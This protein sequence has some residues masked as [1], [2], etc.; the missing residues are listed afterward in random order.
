MKKITLFSRLLL[1]LM[2]CGNLAYAGNK[3]PA[4]SQKP[5][6]SIDMIELLGEL[7]DDDPNALD[8]VL[9]DVD[10]QTAPA[11]TTTDAQKTG[12]KK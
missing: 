7:G 11:N 1:I 3:K 2:V 9:N 6:P 5:P 12:V 4:E 10:K 8:T